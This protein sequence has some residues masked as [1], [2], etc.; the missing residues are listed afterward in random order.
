MLPG[1]TAIPLI[2][3]NAGKTTYRRWSV[4]LVVQLKKDCGCSLC[5]A[6][7]Y[8][9]ASVFRGTAELVDLTLHF[10]RA[11]IGQEVVGQPECQKGR[12]SKRTLKP[13]GWRCIARSAEPGKLRTAPAPTTEKYP[14]TGSSSGSEFNDPT[15][16][17]PH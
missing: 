17:A 2:P 9:G 11:P 4:T 14:G 5:G 12:V 6:P 10:Q 3:T 13:L 7:D 15:V 8:H 1:L 16:P